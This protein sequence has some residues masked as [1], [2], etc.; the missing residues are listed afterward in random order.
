MSDAPNCESD[1]HPYVLLA[2][3]CVLGERMLDPKFQNVVIYEFFRLARL[4]KPGTLKATDPPCR[5]H[6]NIVY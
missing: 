5:S 4:D 6:I 3:M 1:N 2:R